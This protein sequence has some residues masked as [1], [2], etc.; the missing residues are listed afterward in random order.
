MF[1]LHKL[2]LGLSKKFLDGLSLQK[3]GA[4]YYVGGVGPGAIYVAK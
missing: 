2:L 3:C 4:G 1:A